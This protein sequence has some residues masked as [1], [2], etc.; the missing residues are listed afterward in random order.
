MVLT[1]EGLIILSGCRSMAELELVHENLAMIL[2]LKLA[3]R[4]RHGR[5]RS[6]PSEAHVGRL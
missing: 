6:Q 5:R 3:V 1:K 2:W 4:E